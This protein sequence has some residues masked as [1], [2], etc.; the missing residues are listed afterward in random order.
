MLSYFQLISLL[1]PPLIQRG[2]D[3]G[4]A[5]HPPFLENHDCNAVFSLPAYMKG[6]D[7]NYRKCSKFWT[8]VARQKCLDKQGWPRSGCFSE[9]VWSGSSLFAILHAFYECKPWKPTICGRTGREK[10]SNF[11]TFTVFHCKSL[12]FLIF[13][14]ISF[15]IADQY[16][17]E[18]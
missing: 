17:R 5:W 2:G 16:D 18:S 9:S 8:P 3:W 10:C 4:S 12:L 1:N 15:S 7:H 6:W 11:R 14:L 13:L